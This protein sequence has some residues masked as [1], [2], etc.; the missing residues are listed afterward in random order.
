M[1]EEFE[2][3]SEKDWKEL[4]ET[5]IRCS[6]YITKELD[7]P[8]TKS[9][10]NPY[11]DDLEFWKSD[12]REHEQLLNKYHKLEP[13]CVTVRYYEGGLGLIIL[14]SPEK[15]KEFMAEHYRERLMN[16]I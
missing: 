14:N 7:M 10:K 5:K 8:R 15:K 6:N 2:V 3:I 11:G 9:K 1:I 13:V 4:M 12:R 16:Y